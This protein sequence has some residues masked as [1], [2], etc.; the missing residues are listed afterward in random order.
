M[1]L[2]L[3]LLGHSSRDTDLSTLS[4]LF[5]HYLTS[6]D[7]H[8][9]IQQHAAQ[10]KRLYADA[11]PA[12]LAR[13]IADSV[14][15]SHDADLSKRL[16]FPEPP[17][18][19]THSGGG[20]STGGGGGGTGGGGGGSTGGGHNGEFNSGNDPAHDSSGGSDNPN[21]SSSPGGGGGST[22]GTGGTGGGGNSGGGGGNGG[23]GNGGTGGDDSGDGAQSH[24]PR[25]LFSFSFSRWQLTNLGLELFSFEHRH[26][27]L[28]DQHD[29]VDDQDACHIYADEHHCAKPD[30]DDTVCAELH[31]SRLVANDSDRADSLCI[32][33][34][35]SGQ[36]DHRW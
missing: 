18:P 12:N 6:M 3:C 19:P 2:L 7:A 24:P 13:D 31:D 5:L 1:T 9:H 23:T 10:R 36:R 34:G 15:D 17:K 33:R 35:G 11:R 32:A 8:H 4:F 26:A 30:V 28:F 22:G 14:V 21:H 29:D 16:F 25:E 20:G 27:S